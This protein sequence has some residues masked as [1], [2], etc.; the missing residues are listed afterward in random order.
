MCTISSRQMSRAVAARALFLTVMV[1]GGV[2][3]VAT[4]EAGRQSVP[5]PQTLLAVKG[6][7]L[8]FAQD[9]S[10]I[11]WTT[12]GSC[13]FVHL[14]VLAS[15]RQYSLTPPAGET[16][17]ANSPQPTS[18]LALA[19]SRAVWAIDTYSNS[20]E[21]VEVVAGSPGRRDKEVAVNEFDCRGVSAVMNLCARLRSLAPGRRS[22]GRC[23][24]AIRMGR[25]VGW[26][27]TPPFP[28]VTWLAGL[29]DASSRPT[30]HRS[31]LRAEPR[32]VRQSRR[33]PPGRRPVAR[34]PLTASVKAGHMASTSSAR[35]G[36]A[37][38]RLAS[39]SEPAWSP[40]GSRSRTSARRTGWCM[41]S[42]WARTATA[43]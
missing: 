7:I 26:P 34:L 40:N 29:A 42:T 3:F 11:A 22:C 5:A 18:A 32:A 39:G 41:C 8:G 21:G 14:R 2:G 33:T 1:L 12:T 4:A 25:S 17:T 10:R 31:P 28:S 30:D 24:A 38:K 16:C 23:P 20:S 19:G 15:G 35:P 27:E 13:P 9:G 43:S 6:P 37:W 36:G